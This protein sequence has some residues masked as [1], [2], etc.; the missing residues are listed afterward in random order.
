[1]VTGGVAGGSGENAG[2]LW[3]LCSTAGS[4]KAGVQVGRPPVEQQCLQDGQNHMH[5]HGADAFLRAPGTEQ[6]CPDPFRTV[7]LRAPARPPA[8]STCSQQLS[9]GEIPFPS[10]QTDRSSLSSVHRMQATLLTSAVATAIRNGSMRLPA[11][12]TQRLE[13]RH[14]PSLEWNSWNSWNTSPNSRCHGKN[15]DHRR[16]TC[17][18]PASKVGRPDQ[19]RGLWKQ[20]ARTG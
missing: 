16:G 12:P 6:P 2:V 14:P 20:N 3:D 7:H 8:P 13:T 19:E 4:R 18:S 5:K 17:T 15:S 10:S 9:S 1:M 11:P